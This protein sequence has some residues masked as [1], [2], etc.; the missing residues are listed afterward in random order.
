MSQSNDLT[1]F[2]DHVEH[3][4]NFGRDHSFSFATENS[5]SFTNEN[6]TSRFTVVLYRFLGL[7][8]DDRRVSKN[9]R[10]NDVVAWL[11]ER[12]KMMN[13]IEKLRKISIDQRFLEEI[14]RD[15]KIFQNVFLYFVAFIRI[16]FQRDGDAMINVVG[17]RP[18]DRI[19][20]N[21]RIR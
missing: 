9:V 15:E 14:R 13:T 8:D 7:N 1:G 6:E 21:C 11:T 3:R 18:R 5:T 2:A 19:A 17:Q 20:L 16:V 10:T 4:P 12:V